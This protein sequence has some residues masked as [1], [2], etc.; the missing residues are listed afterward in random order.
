[1]NEIVRL[2][3]EAAAAEEQMKRGRQQ[4][5]DPSPPETNPTEVVL[6]LSGISLLHA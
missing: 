5:R 4:A 3:K 2:E 1:M 6:E